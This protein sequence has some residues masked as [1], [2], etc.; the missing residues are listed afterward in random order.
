VACVALDP[1]AAPGNC[2][3]N[4]GL[5]ENVVAALAT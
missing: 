1:I 2:A 5:D 4:S 3:G